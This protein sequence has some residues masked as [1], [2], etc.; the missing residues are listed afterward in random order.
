MSQNT[1]TVLHDQ[2]EFDY[3]ELPATTTLSMHLI[4]GAAAGIMEHSV[5]YP[6]DIVKTRMQ[7]VGS[8]SS[9]MYSGVGQALKVISTTEGMRSLWRGVMS[10]V[11]GA[12]PAHAVY[13]ATYEQT[14][15][16]LSGNQANSLAAGAAGGVATIIS[17]ALMNPFDVIKQ[18]MQLACTT[19]KNIFECARTVF[20]TE[21]FRAFYI[22]YPTTLLMNMPFQTIQFGC[23]DFFRRSLNPS[24]IYSPTTHIIAGG[25]AG[26]VA[27]LLTTP[28]DCCKTLL[29]TRGAST[30]PDVRAASSM[31]DSAKVIY[32]KQGLN[33]FIRGAKPR[34]IA[35]FPATA[36]SWT[37]YE[38]F[39]WVI[40]R[41]ESNKN[42]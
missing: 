42:A 38:Y 3:E 32:N 21:G 12:G 30:D 13:F 9:V 10:V 34:V 41:R 5:M 24:G 36:I 2:V 29:Q 20:K 25:M 15:S 37:T 17:D 35:N 33:G 6:F 28:I 22:S 7:V 8:P 16:I 19:H 11:L 27:G 39:K 40:T 31:I 4:A 1:T 18:R 26:A 23:Y 14:K